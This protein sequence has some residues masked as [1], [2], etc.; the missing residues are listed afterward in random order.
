[1]YL[2]NTVVNASN[3]AFDNLAQ[4]SYVNVL[5]GFLNCQSGGGDGVG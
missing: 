3:V 2:L 1:M 5:L 4:S